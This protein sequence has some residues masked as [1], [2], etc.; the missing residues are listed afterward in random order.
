MEI[1]VMVALGQEQYFGGSAFGVVGMK[2]PWHCLCELS[3]SGLVVVVIHAL[4]CK[5]WLCT[6]LRNVS[7]PATQVKRRI[8]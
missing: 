4:L 5:V 3:V 8:S 7:K 1:S 2:N 6:H